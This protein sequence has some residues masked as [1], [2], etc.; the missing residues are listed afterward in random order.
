VAPVADPATVSANGPDVRCRETL[1]TIDKEGPLRWRDPRAGPHRISVA[2]ASAL[3]LA[4]AC[5]N[6]DDPGPGA[7]SSDVCGHLADAS[8]GSAGGRGDIAY[9]SDAAG[10]VDLWLMRPDRSDQAPLVSGN[11]VQIFPAWSPDG[12]SLAYT[13]AVRANLDA[14]PSDICRIRLDDGRVTNLTDTEGTNEFAP[15]WSPDGQHIAYTSSTDDGSTIFVMGADGTHAHPLL[16][17]SGNYGWPSW[18]PDGRQIVFSGSPYPGDPDQV[19]VVDAA[20]GDPRALT[21]Q[22]DYGTGE[23]SWSPNGQL[24]AYV[25][26]QNGDPNSTDPPDWNEDVYVMNADGSNPRQ[27]TSRPGNEH[28]PPVWSPDSSQLLYTSDGPDENPDL[29]LVPFEDPSAL[30]ADGVGLT[31][32]SDNE[33][34]AAW[35][36]P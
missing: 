13:G 35:R 29:Y 36:A 2:L 23:P 33:A 22:D 5:S 12:A 19:W 20:G 17:S 34:T 8:T 14:A 18:S 16:D 4:T 28:W 27:V 26:D 3:V 1:M 15:S 9:A 10:G 32:T 25:S 31:A 6:A 11:G 7:T 24:I 30:P 21:T